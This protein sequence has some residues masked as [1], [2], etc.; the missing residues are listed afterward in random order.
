VAACIQDP[1]ASVHLRSA[2]RARQAAEWATAQVAAIK[3]ATFT[4]SN[5]TPS[6]PNGH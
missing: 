4:P 1:A 6:T 5:P 3:A 2:E